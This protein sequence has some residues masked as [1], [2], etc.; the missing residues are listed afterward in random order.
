M[1]IYRYPSTNKTLKEKTDEIEPG[2]EIDLSNLNFD[3][4]IDKSGERHSRVQLVV[5]EADFKELIT[6]ILTHYQEKIKS[7][8]SRIEELKSDLRVHQM[9]WSE[10]ELMFESDGSY[11][12]DRIIEISRNMSIGYAE[13]IKPLK[14]MTINTYEKI[15]H[16]MLRLDVQDNASR[17]WK[18][19]Q[20]L[21]STLSDDELIQLAEY[22]VDSSRSSQIKKELC[23]DLREIIDDTSNIKAILSQSVPHE[24]RNFTPLEILRIIIT[25]LSSK[26]LDSNRV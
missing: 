13:G 10:I 22:S 7:Q 14:K 19:I 6:G 17:C 15:L 16:K 2:K 11:D 1:K 3:I 18:V 8:E 21:T 9:F 20:S 12:E 4:T 5:E 25:Y 26:E 23:N 24:K